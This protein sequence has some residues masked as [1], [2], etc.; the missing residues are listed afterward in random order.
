MIRRQLFYIASVGRC[1]LAV[2]AMLAWAGATLG[3]AAG[4]VLP[5]FAAYTL[6][7]ENASRP[8]PVTAASGRI[9][10]EW[11]DVCDG[12]AIAQRARITVT[13]IDGH[14]MDFGWTVNFWE[15][16]DGLRFRFFVRHLRSGGE[17][18]K[19]RGEARLDG[20]D[21]G[22]F[23]TF[24]TP[25]ERTL[26]LPRG[27]MFPV[28]HSLALIAAAEHGELPL[29]RTVFDGSGE[30]G[31]FGVNAALARAFKPSEEA[32]IDSALLEGLNSWRL[33]VAYF[34]L[35]SPAAEPEQEQTVRLF[36]NGVVDELVLDFGD[37]AL[38]GV[39][40]DLKGLPPPDC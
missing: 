22:G 8:G 36:S 12:W 29:W 32:A 23:A 20:S 7:L 10:F 14:G 33:Q 21:A 39:I 16:K 19:V 38:R 24:A 34:A 5:H 17:S 1:A 18:F 11:S 9:E 25:E 30:D 27:T 40:N 35:D 15:S 2:T 37:F 28:S 3:G 13:N 26:P 6:R 4:S 31:L